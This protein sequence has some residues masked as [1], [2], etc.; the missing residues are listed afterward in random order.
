MRGHIKKRGK[1]S[2]S[3][4]IDRGRDSEGKRRQTWITV[5]GKKGEAEDRLSEE[6]AKLQAG[7]FVEPSNQTLEIYLESWLKHLD[8]QGKALRTLVDYRHS[9]RRHLIPK[10]GHIPLQK[11]TT[12]TV[13]DYY[14]DRLEKGCLQHEGGLSRRTVVGH[15]KVLRQALGRAVRLR[16]IS[17][18]PCDDATP[19]SP[20]A[21]NAKA[22]EE[23]EMT[24]VLSAAKGTR[25]YMPIYL[26]LSTGLRKG[27]ILAL[28]WKDIDGDHLTVNGT[29]EQA[30]G[31]LAIKTPKT[32]R[33][34]RTMTLPS[35]AVQELRSHRAA[36]NQERL[37]LGTHYQ[38]NDLVFPKVDG[39][40]WPPKS[41][42]GQH[43]RAIRNAGIGRV[44]FHWYRHTHASQLLRMGENVKVVSERLGHASIM[45][46]LDTY[47]HLLK[48]MQE[49]AAEKINQVLAEVEKNVV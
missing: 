46:T 32:K 29:V 11:L 37:L 26:A 43:A 12:Q 5:Q 15:H 44:R 7:T 45:T 10:L 48:G 19:P 21:A 28:K 40:I 22:L 33:S 18:N 27:E 3:I 17:R 30:A 39:Q 8:T 2:W 14:A 9:C 23:S 34:R 41:F 49:G 47:G 38:A 20:V 24:A 31:H 6:L 36:Q 16:L 4:V 25:L 42:D 35:R 13:E 1:N